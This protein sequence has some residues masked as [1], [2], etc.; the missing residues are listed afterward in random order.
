MTPEPPNADIGAALEALVK[1]RPG[2]LDVGRTAALLDE[3]FGPLDPD[4]QARALLDLLSVYRDALLVH[5]GTPVA[6]VNQDAV[7][8]VQTVARAFRPEGLL[9]CMDAIGL[10]RERINANVAP[11]LA[12]E[13]M[14][15]S[16]R[17]EPRS[18]G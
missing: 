11:L 2:Q 18:A 17:V 10:A 13:A 3:S 6:L 16:L 7:E 14:A 8:S 4:N 1:P 12:L 15:L 5:L 9:A